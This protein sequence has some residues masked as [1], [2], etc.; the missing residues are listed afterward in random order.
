MEKRLDEKL[1]LPE[2]SNFK[3]RL[4]SQLRAYER[5]NL[6]VLRIVT[7]SMRLARSRDP[8]VYPYIPF[9]LMP[10]RLR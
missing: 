5:H 7:T 3:Q 10:R 9:T 8:A 6:Q 2:V 1:N 4:V